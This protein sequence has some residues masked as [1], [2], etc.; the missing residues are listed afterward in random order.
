LKWARVLVAGAVALAIAGVDTMNR[1]LA[2]YEF[3]R[4]GKSKTDGNIDNCTECA[5][6][7]GCGCFG[8]GGDGF[9]LS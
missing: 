5:G 2:K 3:L 6:C 9:T 7:N 8:G 1:T 4:V